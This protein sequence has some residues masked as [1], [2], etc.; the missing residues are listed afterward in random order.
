MKLR[1]K[2]LCILLTLT[3][4]VTVVPQADPGEQTPAAPHVAAAQLTLDDLADLH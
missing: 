4:P 3:V 2:L 1:R